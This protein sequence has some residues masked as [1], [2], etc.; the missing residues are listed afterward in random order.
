[1]ADRYSA[2]RRIWVSYAVVFSARWQNAKRRI[3]T[4]PI[5]SSAHSSLTVAILHIVN[6]AEVPVS[7]DQV[8][9]GVCRCTGRH[10]PVVVWPQRAVGFFL[11]AGFLG[12]M[13]YFVPKQAER[14]VYSYRCRSF[15]S[16][17]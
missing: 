11:T 13:Y 16:G 15:T 9:L 2:D 5:G 14:P 6:S 12:I 7:P 10:D 3:S 17:R 1:M 8:V 4:S